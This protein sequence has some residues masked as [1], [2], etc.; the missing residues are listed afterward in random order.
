MPRH[1]TSKKRKVASD[2]NHLAILRSAMDVFSE[3]G[4]HDANLDIIAARANLSKGAIYNHFKN[5]QDLFLSV[6]E[7]GEH[8][9]IHQISET[10]KRYTGVVEMIESS[11]RSYFRFYEKRES[12][13]RVLV[14]EKYNFDDSAKERFRM[15]LE[16]LTK[17]LEFI[18]QTGIEEGVI[19]NIDPHACALMLS[20]VANSLLF[21]W[22]HENSGKKIIDLYKDAVAFVRHGLYTGSEK[23]KTCR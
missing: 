8:Q 9:L 17:E 3:Y 12:F 23:A 19:R 4:Y 2:R 5:K 1:Y 11:M 21:S 14:Q 10:R 15:I 13:F 18:F 22:I 6:I 20:G 7:W 16:N